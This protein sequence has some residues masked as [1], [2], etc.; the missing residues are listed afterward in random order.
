MTADSGL[1]LVDAKSVSAPCLLTPD[2]ALKELMAGNGRFVSGHTTAHQHDLETLKRDLVA[3]QEPFACVLA[4]AD[5]RVPVEIVFDQTFGHLFV[6][7]VAGNMATPEIIASLEYGVAILGTKVIL[8]LGHRDCGA[9]RAAIANQPVPGQISAL[10][11]YLQPAV[12]QSGPDQRAVAETNARLQANRL[13]E[14]STVV[15]EKIKE[16]QLKVVAGFYDIGSGEVN[17]LD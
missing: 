13:C 4:C 2:A 11:P 16:G 12:D 6:T 15:A 9:V 8:V 14:D 17:L 3:R 7:R 10:F 1:R 5:S